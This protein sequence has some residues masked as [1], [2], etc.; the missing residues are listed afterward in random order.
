MFSRSTRSYLLADLVGFDEFLKAIGRY[1]CAFRGPSLM[2]KLVLTIPSQETSENRVIIRD[3]QACLFARLLFF[4]YTGC[5]DKFL[6]FSEIQCPQFAQIVDDFENTQGTSDIKAKLAV[7]MY[8][9]GEYYDIASLQVSAKQVFLEAFKIRHRLVNKPGSV[10]TEDAVRGHREVINL[11]YKFTR[12]DDR[13]LRDIIV[14]R[15]KYHIKYKQALALARFLETLRLIPDFAIDIAS[16]SLEE[17]SRKCRLCKS[18]TRNLQYRCKCGKLAECS[19]EECCQLRTQRSFCFWCCEFGVLTYT[20]SID[21]AASTEPPTK[22][23]RI[24]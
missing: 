17:R 24:D 9:L 4:L 23:A 10:M 21:A 6:S 18:S 19:E 22:R 8:H 11:V 20:P 2:C 7:W 5:D 16:A 12:E 13:T 1:S 14:R 15:A 3:I